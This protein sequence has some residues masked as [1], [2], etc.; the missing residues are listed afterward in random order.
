MTGTATF[1]LADFSLNLTPT[2]ILGLSTSQM[3]HAQIAISWTG[4]YNGNV[5]L[6]LISPSGLNAS[7]S[8][9]TITGSGTVT[10]NVSSATAGTYNLVVNAT[11]G[12]DSHAVTLTVT[13]SPTSTPADYTI[14]YVGA[15]IGIAAVAAGGYLLFRRGK[16]AKK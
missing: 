1:V 6:K 16:R 3:A 15:G 10:V 4:Q 14:V 5:T 13:V 2:S 8:S 9:A 7:L 11:S 12:P